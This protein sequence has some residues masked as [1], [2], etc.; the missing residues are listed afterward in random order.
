VS[1]DP[2]ALIQ[3]AQSAMNAD[4]GERVRLISRIAAALAIVLTAGAVAARELPLRV[5]TTADGL[6]DNRVKR[7]LSDSRG[8]LWVSTNS[9]INR[10][11]GTHFESFGLS[12][13]LPHPII[14][15]LIETS[16]GD[17]WLASNGAGVVRLR[18]SGPRRYEAFRV[19]AEPTS[20]RVN[21]LHRRSDGTIW[22]GTDGGL[23][24][25]TTGA[26]GQATF[27]QVALSLPGHPEAM[28]QVWSFAVDRE[29]SLW[30]GTR[31]GLIRILPDGRIVSYAVRPDPDD[32]Q[33]YGL[34]YSPEDGLLWI[35]HQ[36]G[37]AIFK[38]PPAG[39]YDSTATSHPLGDPSLAQ[40]A[41]R[42]VGFR[43]VALPARAGSAVYIETPGV[44]GRAVGDFVRSRDGAIVVVSEAHVWEWS[45]GQ[46]TSLSDPRL[47]ALVSAGED[48]EGNL[49]FATQAA[50]LVRMARGGFL[51]FREGDGLG[52]RVTRV[53]ET[54][55][56]DLIVVTQDWQVSRFDGEG[57]RSVRPNVPA[58]VQ[59]AGWLGEVLEDREGDWWFATPAGLFRFSNIARLEDLETRTPRVYP[60]GE[61]LPESSVGRMFADSKGDVWI[62]SFN[63]G[64]EV[65]TRWVRASDTFVTYSDRD[66]LRPYNGPTGYFEDGRGVLWITFRDG[67][68]A[69]YDGGRFRLLTEADGLPTTTIGTSVVDAAGRFWYVAG[70]TGL[71]RID[72]LNATP[73]NPIRVA[74][75]KEMAGAVVARITQDL[76]GDIYA[77]SAQGVVRLDGASMTG[78]SPHPR[79]VAIYTTNDGL[80]GSEVIAAYRDRRGRLWFGTTEG[81]SSY[82]PEQRASLLPPQI[83][84]GALRVAGVDTLVSAAGEESLSGLELEP[85]RSQLEIGF[86]GVS[87]TTGDA[88]SFEYRLIGASDEWSAPSASRTV[89]FANL[90]PGAYEFEVR[91]ISAGGGRSPRPARASFRVLPPIWRRWWFVTL[92]SVCAL[93]AVVAFERYRAVHRREINRAREERLAELEQVR[94]RIAADLHDEIGSSLTQI[95]ILS[96]VAARQGADALPVLSRPLSMIATSSRELVDAMSDVVWAINPDKDHLA[97]LTQRM[98]RLAADTFTASNTTLHLDLPPRDQEV[99]L[100]A[101]MRREVFLIFKEAVNNIVKHAGCSEVFIRFAIERSRL[102]LDL[103]DN[104]KGFDPQMESDGH[105]LA[106]LRSRAATLG[107]TLTIDSRPGA[108]TSVTLDLPIPT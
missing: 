25:L 88:L 98:R 47:R 76:F 84:L 72:D 74:A 48:R 9:G 101:N 38:P 50:G 91:A 79:I 29:G 30:V 6:N 45:R 100:G 105:G 86:F 16:G 37:F 11:D 97:D 35:G 34:L 36:S 18:A 71:Y 103:R 13:G 55:A 26:D 69:R 65:L 32:D 95:S 17:F 78:E 75:P 54:R 2:A 56:G 20:N 53:F 60:T 51:T 52:R 59:R 14:N 68:I 108:G 92:A 83:R 19:S 96:E 4:L 57:F 64:R 41:Q 107:G 106:S 66:G 62:G 39:V 23:F 21:R 89:T 43:N 10:F 87:Y 80:A 1:I 77:A 102:R 8:L 70:L 93:G 61:Q 27:T 67:G 40:A 15:D 49:W 42:P 85:G 81:V 82:E 63:P 12:D 24:R 5:F 46:F 94:R 99:K 7:I 31:F 58:S 44:E 22:V 3:S 90:A 28:V 73:L 104:G 33:V